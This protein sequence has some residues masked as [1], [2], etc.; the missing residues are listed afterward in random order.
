M[1]ALARQPDRDDLPGADDGAEP[2]EDHRRPGGRNAAGPRPGAPRPRRWTSPATG[3]TASAC[4]KTASRSTATRTS[5]RAASAS[6]SAS[7][8]RSRC[9]PELLIA[10]E[11]TTALDVTTQAQILDL[12]KGLVAEEGMSLLLITHDLAVVAGHGRPRR[13]DA[14]RADRRDRARPSGCFA[15][16]RHPYTRTLFAASSHQP[17]RAAQAARRCRCSRSRT[18]CATTPPPRTACSAAPGR[19]RAVDGVSFTLNRGESLGLVGEV[20]L[21]QVHPDPRDP[22]ARPAAGRRRSGSTARRSI[23]GPHARPGR[24]PAMQVVFQD[25]YGSFNPRWRVER[26]VAE[27]FHLLDARPARPARPG[28]R[29]ARRRRPRARRRWTATSTSFPAASASASPSPAR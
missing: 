18:R 28:R 21:R 17:D 2:G 27:P 6:G 29:G 10:D 3:S 15:T 9:S 20:G 19:F 4:P 12:L 11:P 8:W 5:C 26:L 7:P 14:G 23:A 25:P 22:R 1:C 16:M 13:G 24:A